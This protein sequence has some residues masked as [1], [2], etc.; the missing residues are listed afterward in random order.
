[1]EASERYLELCLRLGRHVDGL[2]DAYY[3]PAEIA[4]RVDGEELRDP[5]ALAEDAG[6]LLGSLDG[7]AWLRAQLVGL[8]TVARKLAGEEIGY[9]DEVERCYGVRPAWTPEESFAGAHRELD[10]VLPG[11][12]PLAERYMAWREGEALEGDAIAPVFQAVT[13][14]F[15]SRTTSLFELPEGE[16]VEV[17]YVSDEPW[18]AFNYYQ[19]GLRSR[20]AVNTDIPM[21][22]DLLVGLVAHEAYPGHHTEH[23]WKEQLHVRERGR[24]EES[25][26][27]VGTPSCLIGEGIAQL[28]SEILLADDLER[29]T[30]AHVEGTGVRYDPDLSRAVREANRP[31]G[32]VAANVALLIHTRGASEEEAFEYSMRW[33]LSS[34]RRAKQSVR[35]VTDPVWRSYITT[36]TDGYELCR[37]WVGGDPARFK[38]LLTEELTPA[39][40]VE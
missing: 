14:E 21:T 6:S 22:P 24:L 27:M 1:V 38:R 28:A 34:P 39:D 11:D 5:A 4:E 35:F 32:Y 25:A 7:N 30:A 8:E 40:L 17:D 33:G 19:G 10:E 20:I 37:Q 18:T 36:Y 31:I 2:V 12:G 29:V 15:R 26:L 23:S 9:E 16:S 13:E 3:G